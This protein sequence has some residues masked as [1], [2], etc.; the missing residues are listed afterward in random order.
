MY[1][2]CES[3]SLDCFFIRDSLS[4]AAFSPELFCDGGNSYAVRVCVG[5]AEQRKTCCGL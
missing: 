4:T 5:M 1:D 2:T 3:A